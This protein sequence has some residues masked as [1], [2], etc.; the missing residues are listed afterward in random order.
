MSLPPFIAHNTLDTTN[1]AKKTELMWKIHVEV[2]KIHDKLVED[3]ALPPRVIPPMPVYGPHP[4]K[5]TMEQHMEIKKIQ[6]DL[7]SLR[8]EPLLPSFEVIP[9]DG[10]TPQYL[11]ERGKLAKFHLRQ[12]EEQNERFKKE[13]DELRQ[14]GDQIMNS[15]IHQHSLYV[16][17]PPVTS[18]PIPFAPI[19]QAPIAPQPIIEENTF[20][21]EERVTQPT[22][23]PYKIRK[24]VTKSTK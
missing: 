18:N 7:M 21:R 13:W 23:H 11:Q 14:M 19:F 17:Q 24:R 12:I 1:D 4:L 10:F 16:I 5:F 15:T 9:P 2:K 22:T 20:S 8:T 6:A 3:T